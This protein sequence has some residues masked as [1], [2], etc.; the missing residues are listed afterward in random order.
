V[1]DART[2]AG[3]ILLVLA[4]SAIFGWFM[5]RAAKSLDRAESD[6]SY[7][8][9][10]ILIPVAIYVVST[11]YGVSQVILGRQPVQSLIGLPFV[12]LLI[13]GGLKAAMK[14]GAPPK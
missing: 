14:T 7:R 3:V 9:R 8:R 12:L 10:L 5:F 4:A 2:F 6:P 13:Y 1:R 11:V